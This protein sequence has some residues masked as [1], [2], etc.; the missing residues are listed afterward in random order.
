M[1]WKYKDIAISSYALD[2]ITGV[3]CIKGDSAGVCLR[4][5]SLSFTA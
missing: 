1:Y 5:T 2:H 3:D 4:P